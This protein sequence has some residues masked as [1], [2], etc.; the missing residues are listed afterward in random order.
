MLESDWISAKDDTLIS[1]II[2]HEGD[3]DTIYSFIQSGH[4]KVASDCDFQKCFNENKWPVYIDTKGYNTVG[5]G[6]LVTGKE[7]YNCFDGVT[8]ENVI[9]QLSEDI[10]IHLDGAKHLAE[11]YQ[12]NIAGNYTVQR[13]MVEMCFN[14]GEVRYAK[15]KKG[16]TKLAEA[17]NQ[18]GKNSYNDAADEHL[19]S[20]WAKQVK[21]RAVEMTNTL[22]ELDKT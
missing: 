15:F 9:N 22:R 3:K 20:G 17:V 16:L 10:G 14:L 19:D 11:Q 4:L 5:V 18:T 13:F 2:K 21:Q 7:P 8:D 1:S 12:M 6:H